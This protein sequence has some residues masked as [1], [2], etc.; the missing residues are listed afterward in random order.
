MNSKKHAATIQDVA[1][2]AGVSV[3]TVSRVLNA[4]IDV[5][6][7]T[8]KHI[9]SVIEKLGYTSNLAARSMRS[10][11]NFL[12]GLIMPDVEYPF[13]IEVMKG[14]NRAVAQSE[15]DLVVYTTGNVRKSAAASHE[16]HFI[17]LLNNSITDGVI[18]VAPAAGSFESQ[19]P[20]VSID[21]HQ[22]N[23]NYPSVHATNYQGAMSAMQYLIGLG[24]RRIGFIAGRPELESAKRR[25]S[26]YYDALHQANISLDESL[27]VPG[28]FT[29]KTGIEVAMKLLTQPHPPTAIFAC[30]D[31]TAMGVYRAA[32]RMGL[33]IPS[34]LSV[35][36]FDNIP[37]S[38]FMEL[39]TV[40]QFLTKMGSLATEMLI[41]LINKEKIESETLKIPTELVIRSSCQAIQ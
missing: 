2:E 36:G 4:K 41:K 29:E 3:S 40:D 37:E 34:D 24:H 32:E 25:M 16:Q 38:K 33:K 5:A 27:I 9:L 6:E 21:P 13:A 17:A 28:D 18:I 14:V 20:I 19:S 22:M 8:Q 31:Q 39:T 30:N 7:E 12:I 11:K 1:K 10:R 23:P 35:V 26:G 15:F